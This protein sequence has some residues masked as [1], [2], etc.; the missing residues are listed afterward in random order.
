MPGGFSGVDV[1]FVISGFLISTILLTALI[2]GT[3]GLTQFY[4]RRVRRILPALITVLVASLVIGWLILLENEF[5]ALGK[6]VLGGAFFV[7]NFV[8]CLEAGYFDTTAEFKPLLHLWS[9]AIE[10][11]YYIVWPILLALAFKLRWGQIVVLMVFLASS[12]ILNVAEAPIS[13]VDT[14]FLPTTR[15]WELLVGSLLAYL[16]LH[17]TSIYEFISNLPIG[18][19]RIPRPQTISR[20]SNFVSCSGVALLLVSF[21]V[22]D[23]SK[24]FPGLWALPPTIGAM[25]LIA[26]GPQAWINR[27][28]LSHPVAVFIGKISFPLYLWHWPIL[29]VFRLFSPSG[30][31]TLR[32][33][34]VVA[35]S[36]TFSWL[37]YR[38][39]EGNLRFGK[40]KTVP[41]LLCTAILLVGAAGSAVFNGF[42]TP[43]NNSPQIKKILEA[44]GQWTYPG[45]LK[46]GDLLS[47]GS[48]PYKALLLGDSNMEQYWP[49]IDALVRENNA[50]SRSAIFLTSGGCVPIPGVREVTH[51]NCDGLFDSLQRYADDPSI[52]VVAVA[53]F[54]SGYFS[55]TSTYF[56]DGSGTLRP[57]S[58]GSEEAFKRLFDMLTMFKDQHKKVYLILQIPN[59]SGLDPRFLFSRRFFDKFEINTDGVDRKL[60][61]RRMD[62]VMK[63]LREIGARTGAEVIDPMDF[64]CDSEKCK[65]VMPDG[66]P[67]YKDSSHLRPSFVHQHAKFIDRILL[68]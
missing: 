4:A 61:V 10:E 40:T 51:P 21:W 43:R 34:T 59:A 32:D 50:S 64:L 67:I 66:E 7:S 46:S 48:S 44:I 56:I 65:A 22:L 57:N 20:F 35:L 15:A 39:I 3:F 53:A 58:P 5:K 25:L 2:N 9:L 62:S 16:N 31:E 60:V 68:Q 13:P 27:R 63:R 26:A 12:L 55:E 41:V 37:T 36:L 14:F 28:L 8:L 19:Y 42:V 52:E 30:N 29:F 45:V 47:V 23:G 38:F 17:R 11:Q 1:F 6:H 24:V 54:W 18:R 33:I 49:R